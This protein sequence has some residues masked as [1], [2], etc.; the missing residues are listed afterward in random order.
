MCAAWVSEQWLW[1]ESFFI[2]PGERRPGQGI[3]RQNKPVLPSSMRALWALYPVK[4]HAVSQV[5]APWGSSKW[6]TDKQD[7]FTEF[8][9]C[10]CRDMLRDYSTPDSYTSPPQQKGPNKKPLYANNSDGLCCTALSVAF[11][12]SLINLTWVLTWSSREVSLL[13]HWPILW[14]VKVRT[15]DTSLQEQQTQKC[16]Q[17]HVRLFAVSL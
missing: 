11:P 5:M 17:R 3:Q 2:L 16:I 8:C 6:Q 1:S 12:F 7:A 4:G 13:P 10:S 9:M 15:Y 14:L